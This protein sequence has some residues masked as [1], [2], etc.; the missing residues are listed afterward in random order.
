[1]MAPLDGGQWMLQGGIVGS[2]VLSGLY[3]IF[4][5]CVMKALNA[6]P[7]AS[8]I[9]T[10]NSI[11]TI[12]VNP[13]FLLF[14]MGTPLMC[15]LLLRS[16]FK[17]GMGSSL[18]NTFSAAGAVVLI[19]GEFL[20]TLAVHIPKNDSLAAYAIGSAN[21][22]STWA[23]YYTTWTAWNHVRMAASMVSMV[24][25]SVALHLRAAWLAVERPSPMQ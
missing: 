24:L 14:F 5:F 8:A 19:L 9:A 16:C 7:P 17:E 6:Q 20:L 23:N 18:D 2:G 12:I 1:M 25:F 10:M 22:V 21:D 3:F 4:S 13:P 11:N 15:A